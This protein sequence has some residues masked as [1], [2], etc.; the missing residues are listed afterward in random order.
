MSYSGNIEEPPKELLT[1]ELIKQKYKEDV[2]VSQLVDQRKAKAWGERL[3]YFLFYIMSHMDMSSL[4]IL[5][6]KYNN[7]WP[8]W[9][10]FLIV[11]VLNLT[12]Y[13]MTIVGRFSFQKT[14]KTIKSSN[15][16]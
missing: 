6:G 7:N 10:K 12:R 4:C 1:A 9:P 5:S 2:L 14:L 11:I 16:W 8:L 3:R 13:T 15:H